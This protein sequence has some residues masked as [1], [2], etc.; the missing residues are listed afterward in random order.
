MAALGR[1]RCVFQPIVYAKRPAVFGHEALVRCDHQNLDSPAKLFA[2]AEELGE[3]LA[4]ERAIRSRLASIL[5]ELHDDKP[6]FLNLHPAALDDPE[7]YDPRAPLTRHARGVYIELTERT[8]LDRIDDLGEKLAALRGLGFRI[9]V[10]DLG[11]G[12]QGLRSFAETNPDVVKFD[13]SLVRGIEKSPVHA[14][15]MGAM[16]EACRELRIRTVG[17]GVETESERIRL[18]GLGCQLLQGFRF[19]RPQWPFPSIDW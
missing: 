17:V 7:L 13:M 9:A 4:L 10:D 15:L 1:L 18:V 12:Y 5:A 19:A 11:A 8:P 14:E 2:A 6:V 3:T 16:I